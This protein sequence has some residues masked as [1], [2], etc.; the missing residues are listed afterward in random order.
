VAE[1]LLVIFGDQDAHGGVSHKDR[2]EAK[3]SWREA[4]DMAE[5]VPLL[6][7]ALPADHVRLQIAEEESLALR[8]ATQEAHLNR[9]R[10]IE[11]SNQQ[12]LLQGYSN[13]FGQMASIFTAFGKKQFA[14]AK[15]FS[16]GQAIMNTAQAVTK[17]LAEYSYPINIVFAAITAAAGG[18]QIAQIAS[19]QP[20]S[21]AVGSEFIPASGPDIVHQGERIVQSDIN[22]DLTEFLSGGGG[23]QTHVTILLDGEVLA[24]AMGNMSRDG[25]LEISARAIA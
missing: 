23:G 13:A 6:A 22:A 3:K 9:M 21:Y 24:K 15:A 14:A 1:D 2:G 19:Q 12:H 17:T 16:I 18:A 8:G 25:R 10:A 20:P 11:R 7:A 4:I 5:S